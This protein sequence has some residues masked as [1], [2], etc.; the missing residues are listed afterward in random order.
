MQRIKTQLGT[1]HPWA[2][3]VD[4]EGRKMMASG[5]QRLTEA[6]PAAACPEK[7]PVMDAFPRIRTASHAFHRRQQ[8]C[9][10]HS[11]LTTAIGKI[12]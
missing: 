5:G 3:D 6:A 11:V 4:G 2:V 10:S 1:W 7:S 12:S 8:Y 9:I